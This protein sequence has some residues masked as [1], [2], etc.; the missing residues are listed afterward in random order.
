MS[1]HSALIATGAVGLWF[2]PLSFNIRA[3]SPHGVIR[4]AGSHSHVT[5]SSYWSVAIYCYHKQNTN[6]T[7]FCRYFSLTNGTGSLLP[8][9]SAPFLQHPN[10]RSSGFMAKMLLVDTTLFLRNIV[11]FSTFLPTSLTWPAVLQ[12]AECSPMARAPFRLID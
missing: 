5:D 2:R 1:S 10:G 6:V 7:A 9:D 11:L 4:H 12:T 8:S 3:T